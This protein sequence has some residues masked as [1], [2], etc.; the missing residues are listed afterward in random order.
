[1]DTRA[2]HDPVP[3]AVPRAVPGARTRTSRRGTVLV[4]TAAAALVVIAALLV[5]GYRS[6]AYRAGHDAVTGKGP[7][8]VRQTVDADGGTSLRLC[9]SLHIDSELR[10]AEYGYEE[11]IKGCAAAVDELHGSHVPM[12]PGA[13]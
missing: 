7:G 6:A 1:M 8:W 5:G 9:T 3:G 13:R 10:G 12:W 2:V 11:F 4:I